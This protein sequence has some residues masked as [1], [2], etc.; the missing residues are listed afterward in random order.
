MTIYN[1]DAKYGV[2]L[3]SLLTEDKAAPYYTGKPV[4]DKH[5]Q[6]KWKIL[7]LIP[8]IRGNAVWSEQLHWI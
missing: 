3:P 6:V 4:V 5:L 8:K 7:S 2:E 1:Y